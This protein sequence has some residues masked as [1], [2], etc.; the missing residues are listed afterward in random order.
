MV[1]IAMALNL[2]LEAQT[3]GGF[4]EI[5]YQ[6]GTSYYI[7][8]LNPSNPLNSRFHIAQGGFYRANVNSRIG[9][10]F[11]VMNSTV[12]AWDADSDNSWALKKSPL[13]Q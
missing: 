10:R 4:A 9:V 5:G 13:S 1:L 6:I 7:G 3:H 8:D 2:G 11:Q 12:E